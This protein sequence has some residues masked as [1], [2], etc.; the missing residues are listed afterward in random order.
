MGLA[1]GQISFVVIKWAEVL[2]TC[3]G[4]FFVR[5]KETSWNVKQQG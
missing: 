5:C 4:Q 1:S 3:V 2:G